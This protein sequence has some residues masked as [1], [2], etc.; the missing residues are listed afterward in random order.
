MT[1]K[2]QRYTS[3]KKRSVNKQGTPVGSNATLL[4][5]LFCNN[6]AGG[7]NNSVMDDEAPAVSTLSVH[8]GSSA[9][10]NTSPRSRKTQKAAHAKTTPTTAS[11][12]TTCISLGADFLRETSET[13]TLHDEANVRS[14]IQT[15]LRESLLACSE[16]KDFSCD[17]SSPPTFLCS[18]K[19]TKKYHVATS[20]SEDSVASGPQPVPVTLVGDAAVGS[21]SP[22]ARRKAAREMSRKLPIAFV[23]ENDI[24]APDTKLSMFLSDDDDIAETSS[25][26]PKMITT[27][28]SVVVPKALSSDDTPAATAKKSSRPMKTPGGLVIPSQFTFSGKGVFPSPMD[29][30]YV[31][32]STIQKS[33][34]RERLV[35]RGKVE[36][37]PRKKGTSPRR[38]RRPPT[39]PV[40]KAKD[41]PLS[42]EP[43]F[44]SP[45][46]LDLM[47][48]DKMMNL[49]AT[50]SGS[51]AEKLGDES[52]N[53]E[54]IPGASAVNDES[55]QVEPKNDSVPPIEDLAIQEQHEE[56]KVEDAD[57]SG[58]V[59][60]SSVD[61]TDN[62]FILSTST[63]TGTGAL[64]ETAASRRDL[65]LAPS[66]GVDADV[67]PYVPP[68]QLSEQISSNVSASQSKDSIDCTVE[69]LKAKYERKINEQKDQAAL[70]NRVARL[71]LEEI[72]RLE[73]QIDVMKEKQVN[74]NELLKLRD[75]LQQT[76]Q[77]K[78]KEIERVRKEMEARIEDQKKASKSLSEF[79]RLE[80]ELESVKQ[81]LA[82][83]ASSADDATN[84]LEHLDPTDAKMSTREK[85]PSTKVSKS[86]SRATMELQRLSQELAQVKH[87][88]A[89]LKQELDAKVNTTNERQK[90]SLDEVVL[91]SRELVDTTEQLA[92]TTQH[93]ALEKELQAVR[94]ELSKISAALVEKENELQSIKASYFQN[95]SEPSAWLTSPVRFTSPITLTPPKRTIGKTKRQAAS[96]GKSTRQDDV[97]EIYEREKES[98]RQQIAL[99]DQ[100]AT[101]SNQEHERALAELR[102]ASE[103][104][105]TRVRKEM[106][107]KL[108]RHLD[109]ERTLKQSLPEV[110]SP[111]KEELLEQIERL[112][113]EKK[114]ERSGGLRDV[115][116]KEELFL[117]ISTMEA[118]EKE[119]L[120]SHERAIQDLRTKGDQEIQKLKAQM[121]KQ[122]QARAIRERELASAISESSSYEKD[123]LLQKTEKLQASLEKERDGAVL[124]KIQI[125]SLEKELASS[126]IEHSSALKSLKS[127]ADCEIE[128]HK[129]ELDE[130]SALE[131]AM[132]IT[133][134][135]RDAAKEE[136][137]RLNA[138]IDELRKKHADEVAALTKESSDKIERIDRDS[139][140]RMSALQRKADEQIKDLQSANSR[141][142][143]EHAEEKE[144][145]EREV[146]AVEETYKVLITESNAQFESFQ[147]E[148]DATVKDLEEELRGKEE[149]LKAELQAIELQHRSNQQDL[150][151]KYDELRVKQQDHENQMK[152]ADDLHNKQFEDLLNQLDIVEAEHKQATS[153]KERAL[154]EKEAVV[155]ALGSQLAEAQRKISEAQNESK[156]ASDAA[157]QTQLKCKSLEEQCQLLASEILE[158]KEH[159]KRFAKEAAIARE[160]ACENAREEMIEKAE[161]Q[162]QQAN[163]HYVKLRKQYDESQER[164]KKLEGELKVLKK[165]HE[166]LFNDKESHEIELKSEVAKL[167]AANAKIEAESAIKAKEYRREMERLLATA[168]DFEA[169][170]EEAG[171]TSRSI[172]TTL[173]T[174]VAE[175]EK[176]QKEYE[177]M[178]SVSEE[179]MAIVEG[180][181]RHEC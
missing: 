9:E 102:Q 159:Q 147:R 144:K 12:P 38:G 167:H 87:E 93:P 52:T 29:N 121:V 173:A 51:F 116:K 152:E 178:K 48:M 17:S 16:N 180:Q 65:P 90:A 170:A 177:E 8:S 161:I 163:E 99:L 83:K 21:T 150:R 160:K 42:D 172:Q 122:E 164:A 124:L 98:L 104:E 140:V 97:V 92:T 46:S 66:V 70:A 129:A 14:N 25:Q 88:S 11:T 181:E 22:T 176:L 18:G 79:Q 168:K 113:A 108:E 143:K 77:E 115:Q 101:E 118:K 110:S 33:P 106:E 59:Y 50:E 45:Q 57:G 63:G 26:P 80:K 100:Q 3:M 74:E 5:R 112:Q 166:K 103:L 151:E 20:A 76:Q 155:D 81:K 69:E 125:A 43:A 111:E 64:E 28:S 15:T 169:K 78:K 138:K 13:F 137:Q 85:S 34:P 136:L 89:S 119:L 4:N 146:R 91:S 27:R 56:R 134:N 139:E 107:S 19:A 179:L 174:V 1:R 95:G 67:H 135:E 75:R 58:A 153:Q 123:E 73:A 157:E 54:R 162:F 84:G 131:V 120:E 156:H 109:K 126:K 39:S 62:D 86:P 133:S 7:N 82:M 145:L 32:S 114:L 61:S 130:R 53:V 149:K 44:S 72:G 127:T 132:Q 175:K 41:K 117:R 128:R 158:L 2:A 165:K 141:L 35:E 49:L 68:Y 47:P 148:S 105:I 37:S 60:F 142:C 36:K 55:A 71:R 23:E 24:E 31:K 6:P 171:K 94:E 10:E 40:H 154:S 30:Y 96:E